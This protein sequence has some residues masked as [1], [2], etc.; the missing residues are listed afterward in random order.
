MKR[1]NVSGDRWRMPKWR[2][3]V[4]AAVGILAA[5]PALS[6]L[7]P[8]QAGAVSG[9]LSTS[10]ASRTPALAANSDSRMEFFLT[11]AYDT[12]LNRWQ[13]T[14]GSSQWTGWNA[15]NGQVRS[16]AV[17]ARQD[18]A[19]ELF[20]LNKNG[21]IW[22]RWQRDGG[23]TNW[24]QLDGNLNSIAVARAGNGLLEV[25]GTNASGT[26]FHRSQERLNA[27]EWAPWQTFDGQLVSVAAETNA[28]GRLEVFGVNKQ[29]MVYHQW[30]QTDGRWSGWALFD[31]NMSSVAVARNGAGRLELFATSVQGDVFHRYQID[32]GWSRWANISHST[33]LRSVAADASIDGRVMVVGVSTNGEAFYRQQLTGGGWSTW[34]QMP[35]G[36][37]PP[38]RAGGS[39]RTLDSPQTV[40][41]VAST[42][43]FDGLPLTVQNASSA[44]RVTHCNDAACTT[45]TSTAVAGATGLR[46]VAVK[47]GWDGLP[48]IAFTRYVSST[49]PM[50]LMVAKCH[51]A[52]CTASTISVIDD[53]E[54]L[55]EEIDLTIS[56]DGLPVVVYT[57][58]PGS[59]DKLLKVARCNNAS[60]TGATVTN[61]G[62]ASGYIP[63]LKVENGVDGLPN[64]F[65][66]G[67]FNLLVARCK[68]VACN[69]FENIQA[70]AG[71]T[72]GVDNVAI[73]RDNASDL[74]YVAW[75]QRGAGGLAEL[76]IRRCNFRF[77]V[78][79]DRKVLV[80]SGEVAGEFGLAFGDDRTVIASFKGPGNDLKVVKC[81]DQGCTSADTYTVENGGDQGSLNSI[82]IGADG[83]PIIS[84]QDGDTDRL[85]LAH[86]DNLSCSGFPSTGEPTPT[87]TPRPTPTPTPGAGYKSVVLYN[88]TP[89][90]WTVSIWTRD[91]TTGGAWQRKTS[92]D[93]QWTSG[94]TCGPNGYTGTPYTFT[95]ETNHYYD[96]KA[97]TIEAAGCPDIPDG[98]S[99][100]SALD[101]RYV[102]G[103]TSGPVGHQII[104]G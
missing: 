4:A 93:P 24:A 91:L 17:E 88:C 50:V 31:G 35:A 77:C 48:V 3:V 81:A 43:G 80:P 6:L 53:S 52:A 66:K 98:N 84:Y 56:G 76:V 34:T 54:P 1:G 78:S 28:D 29:G 40:S 44:L 70:E 103:N 14:P 37:T 101:L 9:D 41:R 60:C 39:V 26:V 67:K 13:S 58:A 21:D 85:K 87:P 32:G 7:P 19:L 83:L 49:Q 86:C 38:F 42:I 8:S 23:W 92:L 2:S 27:N 16:L 22:H 15:F 45:S 33:R 11:D 64:F 73:A 102:L 69:T 59:G 63:A 96:I 100:C 46:R 47:T 97:V 94:G 75:T 62:L 95:M 10:L 5:V 74:T 104:G 25:F 57:T 68:T 89:S 12:A 99:S 30:K 51:N 65:F 72:G 61:T 18:R 82:L 90:E 71:P 79:G 20:G 55:R 36:V